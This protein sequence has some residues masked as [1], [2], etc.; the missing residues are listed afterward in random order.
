[1]QAW[2]EKFNTDV[3]NFILHCNTVHVD[4]NF[5]NDFSNAGRSF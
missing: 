4:F 2:W 3:K 5:T 1:M